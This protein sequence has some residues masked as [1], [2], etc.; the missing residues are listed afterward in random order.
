MY[1]RCWILLAV[2]AAGIACAPSPQSADDTQEL[3]VDAAGWRQLTL[4]DVEAMYTLLRDQTPIPFDTENPEYA[5]WLEEG[6]EQARERAA[7]VNQRSGYV[8]TLT[9]YANGFRDTHIVVRTSMP[10][11]TWPGFFAAM[12]GNEVIV[13]LRDESD[14]AAPAVGTRIES[15]DGQ[16][17]PEL[18]ES[19]VFAY[20]LPVGTSER[21]AVN[22]LFLDFGNPYLPPLVECSVGQGAQVRQV[23]LRW[24]STPAVA[25]RKFGDLA[26]G[27]DAT[28]GLTE[29]APGVFWLGLPSLRSD[30]STV[31]RQEAL[32]EAVLERGEEMRKA[33]AIVIDIR[34]NGGGH[35]DWID[36]LTQ[37]VFTPEV[38]EA[39]LDAIP[40]RRVAIDRRASPEI[41]ARLRD[42]ERQ[43]EA[44][45]TRDLRAT[46]RAFVV[47]LEEALNRDPPIWREGDADPDPSGGITALRPRGARS[48]FP[49]RVYLLSNGTCTSACLMLADVVLMVPG[50]RLIGADTAGDTPYLEARSEVLPSGLAE[51]MFPMMVEHG[52]LRGAHEKYTADDTYDGPWDDASVRQWTLDLINAHQ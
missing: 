27:P 38:V 46:V 5:R 43:L 28:W 12:R 39:A 1:S 52:R 44:T 21:R 41:L 9:G 37:A 45:A 31:S 32:V 22:E 49:A 8:F 19:R 16:T 15:C 7:T 4:R 33:R 26:T 47:G 17:V 24:R 6:Y 25:Q 36:R 11:P 34:G 2:L 3:P 20:R 29:P 48:P 18:L 42:R 23:P 51:L 40:P 50:V 35:T 13:A 10:V 14:P 30:D